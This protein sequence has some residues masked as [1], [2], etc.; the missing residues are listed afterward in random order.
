MRTSNRAWSAFAIAAALGAA[1]VLSSGTRARAQAEPMTTAY[2]GGVDTGSGAV[3]E[4]VLSN[5]SNTSM[6][7]DLVLRDG[8]GAV[9]VNHP[10][11]IPLAGSQTVAVDL[12]AQLKRDVPRGKK[13]YRGIVMVEVGGDSSFGQDS[14]LVHVT[15][16]FGSR[17]RPR[18]AFVLRP[19]YRAVN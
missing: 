15:Q 14:V 10:A 4:L 13:P 11:E 5:L 3:P 1:A 19:A 6:T 8:A 12:L 7:L 9:L 18:A 17:K 16:Y 2:V